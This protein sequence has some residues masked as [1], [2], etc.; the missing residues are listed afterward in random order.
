MGYKIAK[1]LLNYNGMTP[2]HAMKK[3]TFIGRLNI[4]WGKKCT[5]YLLDC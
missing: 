4:W 2:K 3:L 5:P 1:Y